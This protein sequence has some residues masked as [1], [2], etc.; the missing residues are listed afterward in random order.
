MNDFDTFM[1]E[2][3]SD[4]NEL[5]SDSCTLSISGPTTATFSALNQSTDMAIFGLEQNATDT[6]FI[7]LG[8]ISKE[9]VAR[10][11]LTKTKSNEMY[12]V[13]HVEI[14][15]AGYT[16]ALKRFSKKSAAYNG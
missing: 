7:A 15:S 2:A 3:S 8:D 12:E 11:T 16:L 10:E 6:A 4:A 1:Q 14:D 5:T 13:L 9:P